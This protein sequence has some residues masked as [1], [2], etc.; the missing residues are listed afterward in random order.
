MANETTGA[1]NALVITVDHE[2]WRI[3]ELGPASYDRRG[4]NTL[5]FESD[6]FVRRVRVYPRN[7]RELSTEDLLRLSW[8]S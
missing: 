5:V 8:M 4:T 6:G 3:Y 7:W 1:A 2:E